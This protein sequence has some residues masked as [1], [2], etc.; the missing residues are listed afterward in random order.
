MTNVYDLFDYLANAIGIGQAIV[1]MPDFP[2][3]CG[4]RVVVR[5]R[6]RDIPPN[7]SLKPTWPAQCLASARYYVWAG[8]A[9]QLEAIS[10]LR[11]AEAEQ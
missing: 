10:L 6:A 5:E 1:S 9:A 2:V 8:Q 3:S 4:S 11:N 7:N